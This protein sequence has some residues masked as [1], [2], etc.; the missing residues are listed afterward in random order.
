VNE[1]DLEPFKSDLV[2]SGFDIG[3]CL[4]N[5]NY[6]TT[7]LTIM[8]KILPMNTN[9]VK[10]VVCWIKLAEEFFLVLFKDDP[11]IRFKV[12]WVSIN[13]LHGFDVIFKNLLISPSHAPRLKTFFFRFFRL[14]HNPVFHNVRFQHTIIPS[15]SNSFLLSCLTL[16]ENQVC[17]FFIICICACFFVCLWLYA[18]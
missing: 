15:T 2:K 16:P 4:V 8:D 17:K 6:Q 7:M 12:L 5:S 18:E 3:E 13:I 1:T 9:R 11:K 10:L 14:L